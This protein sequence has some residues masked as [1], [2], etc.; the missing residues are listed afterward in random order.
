[1]HTT[2]PSSPVEVRSSRMPVAEFYAEYVNK[3]PVLIKGALN[4]LPAVS[5]WSLGYF[6][7][8][9]PDLQVRLKTGSISGGTAINVQLADYH[10]L[11]SQ[12]E[13]GAGPQTSEEQPPPYLHDIP[14]FS[15]IPQLQGDVDAF[16][17][18][19]L[20]RFF[21]S[22]WRTFAQFFVGPSQ[23]VTPLHFDTLL[24]HNLFFQFH[25]TKRFLMVDAADRDCCYTYNWRWSPVDPDDPDLERFPKFGQV[26]LR[27]CEV[28]DGDILYMPPG[29]L[30]KVTSLTSSVSFNID[31][32]DR[33]S[34]LRG[35]IAGLHQMPRQNLRYNILLALGVW[36][37]VPLKV[38]M[39]ALRSYFFYIS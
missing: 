14:L 4:G 16:P 33:R 18:I 1:M 11:V 7:S 29:T 37:G 23:A 38:L 3:K 17:V 25:G 34:A 32:H 13:E 12:W 5:A 39:P 22:Q 26:R 21:R 24:T 35:L 8:L 31:W 20:P 15:L 36:A 27:S 2:I 30:H 10:R 28:S 19:L 9:A 6:A